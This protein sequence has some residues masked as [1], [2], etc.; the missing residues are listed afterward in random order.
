MGMQKI[1]DKEYK[2]ML[3]QYGKGEYV[4]L[5]PY[6]GSTKRIK[7]KHL[8][9]GNEYTILA[10]EFKRGHGRCAVCQK[11]LTRE[12]KLYQ[13]KEKLYKLYGSEYTVLS[14]SYKTINNKLKVRHNVC[15]NVLEVYPKE[16]LRTDICYYCHGGIKKNNSQFIKDVWQAVSNEYTFLDQYVNSSTKIRVKHNKCGTIYK[17]TPNNFLRGHGR[18]PKCTLKEDLKPKNTKTFKEQLEDLHPNQYEVLDPYVNNHTK[19]RV[20]HLVCGHV[21]SVMPKNLLHRSGC[22][23]CANNIKSNTAQFIKK[24]KSKYGDQYTIL[25]KYKTNKIKLRVRCNNCGHVWKIKPDNLL[26]GC[27]CPQCASSKGEKYVLKALTKLNIKE[28]SQKTFKDLKNPKTNYALRFDFYIPD[29]NMCI[30]YD[31]KQ[32]YKPINYFGGIDGYKSRKYRDQ[33]KNQYCKE[34]NI[35]LLRIPYTYNTYDKIR[36]LLISRLS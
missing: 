14:K 34:H 23:Y 25:D 1:T 3:E 4:A 30:E 17:T 35:K 19:I 27:G 18:C 24:V 9:C 20:K 15:G 31:G 5:S 33:L 26:N 28:V 21:W 36:N 32:H 22:P 12:H 7:I 6:E 29:Y 13:F 8:V 11:K 2:D 16:L 10:G